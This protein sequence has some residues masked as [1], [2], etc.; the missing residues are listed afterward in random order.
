MPRFVAAFRNTCV[1]GFERRARLGGLRALGE[2]VL[3]RAGRF[4]EHVARYWPVSLCFI[5]EI[6]VQMEISSLA[7]RRE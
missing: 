5:I 3:H 2:A 1:L 7:D 4:G 6:V